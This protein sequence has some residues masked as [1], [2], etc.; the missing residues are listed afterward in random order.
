MVPC[1]ACG[2][3]GADVPEAPLP[4]CYVCKNTGLVTPEVAIAWR[5]RGG[6]GAPP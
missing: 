4:N 6:K 3:E 5:V 2:R 1:P